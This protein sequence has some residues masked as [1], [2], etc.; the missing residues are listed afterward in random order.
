LPPF[1]N[2]TTA[3]KNTFYLALNL[4]ILLIY[5][6]NYVLPPSQKPTLNF[7]DFQW[8]WQN[9]WFLP[10]FRFWL[11]WKYFEEFKGSNSKR[12]MKFLWPSHSNH[13]V[14]CHLIEHFLDT[15]WKVIVKW[16]DFRRLSAL[17]SPFEWLFLKFFRATY[18]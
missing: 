9:S 1:W 10:N 14:K 5:S 11:V 3:E 15:V 2:K 4:I 6:Q 17:L 8:F 16:K 7:I 12:L 13:L 18:S